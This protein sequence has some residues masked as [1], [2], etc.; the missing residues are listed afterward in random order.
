MPDEKMKEFE[1]RYVAALIGNMTACAMP[2]IDELKADRSLCSTGRWIAQV[3]GD[4]NSDSWEIS[5]VRSG[6]KHGRQS[7]GWF[8]SNK[9]RISDNGGPYRHPLAPGIGPKMVKLAEEYAESL[10]QDGPETAEW[11]QI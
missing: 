4:P 6:N 10:N 7:Y 3:F 8:D 9:L 5:V 11:K 1:E 2:T